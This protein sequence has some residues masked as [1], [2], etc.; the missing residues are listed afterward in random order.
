MPRENLPAQATG[1]IGR[2]AALGALAGFALASAGCSGAYGA[3]TAEPL[4]TS[5]EPFVRVPPGRHVFAKTIE[6][7]P[8]Q[9]WLFDNA[10]IVYQGTG[11]A[12]VASG[13]N[14]AMLGR[15]TIEGPKTSTGLLIEQGRAYRVSG[16]RL[17]GLG[18]GIQILDRKDTHDVPRG[19]R[20]Q[21]DNI[22]AKG[23]GI[24]IDVGLAAEYCLFTN[25]SALGCEQGIVV[26]AGSVQFHGGNVIDCQDGIVLTNGTNGGHGGF[27]GV[28]VN[29]NKRHNLVARDIAYGH[30]FTGCHF[31][32]DGPDKGAILLANCSGINITG[33]QLDCAVIADGGRGNVLANN[34]ITGPNFSVAGDVACRGNTRLDGSDACAR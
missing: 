14:W 6:I 34:V 18:N 15:A 10:A 16:L 21:F 30:T 32:G 3:E 12:F 25:A 5:A 9:V 26:S 28:N 20:G 27:H 2:R 23:C 33:G 17:Q 13:S 8:G 11:P 19:D 24:G 1:A 7:P 22:T 4:R 31:Y 29:H